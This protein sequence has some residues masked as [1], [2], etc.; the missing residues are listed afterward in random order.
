[1]KGMTPAWLSGSVLLAVAAVGCGGSLSGGG[2]AGGR[3]PSE[4]TYSWGGDQVVVQVGPTD[5]SRGAFNL[6]VENLAGTVVT[7]TTSS[8]PSATSFPATDGAYSVARYGC[9]SALSEVE[10]ESCP[11]GSD[12]RPA[13]GCIWMTLGLEGATGAY[14]NADGATCSLYAPMVNM[15]LPSP[16]D[17]SPDDDATRG[18][19][20]FRCVRDDGTPWQIH[21]DFDIALMSTVLL[22]AARD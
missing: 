13:P 5:A 9:S 14:V 3:S 21:G 1:L 22:C 15:T 7:D 10:I 16:G 12:P 2:G 8:L 18:T 17:G 11:L 20:S 6:H 19:F 4:G